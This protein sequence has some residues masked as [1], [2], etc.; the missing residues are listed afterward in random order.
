MGESD[1]GLC[2]YETDNKPECTLGLSLKFIYVFW[3]RAMNFEIISYIQTVYFGPMKN[4]Q[5]ECKCKKKG[6]LKS[7]SLYTY[8]FYQRFKNVPRIKH[9]SKHLIQQLKAT[10]ITRRKKMSKRLCFGNPRK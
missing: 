10:E 2:F 9:M 8:K 7:N 4:C 3:V 5:D 6:S 1:T